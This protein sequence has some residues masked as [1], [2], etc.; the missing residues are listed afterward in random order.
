MEK[1]YASYNGFAPHIYNTKG[2]TL[3]SSAAYL[4]LCKII[5]AYQKC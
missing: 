5:A 2:A 1:S 4:L 3:V